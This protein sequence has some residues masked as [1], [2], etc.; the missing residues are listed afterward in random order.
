VGYH[1]A[2]LVERLMRDRP[3]P[4]QG[5]RSALGVLSLE[6]RFGRDR[7][8]AACDRALAHSTVSYTSVQSILVTGLDRAVA[9]PDPV[10]PTPRHDNIRGPAYYQ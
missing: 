2:V 7:L 3:H 8:E 4:E 9:E 5:Y 1:V 10:R 6:R